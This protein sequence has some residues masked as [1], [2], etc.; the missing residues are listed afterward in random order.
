MDHSEALQQMAAERY[1]LDEMTPDA[2]EAFEEHLFDCPECALDLRAGAAFV[3]EAKAQLPGLTAA[4]PVPPSS[5]AAKSARKWNHWHLWWRPAFAIPAFA[6]LLI[7]LGYQNL[8]TLPEL[9]TEANQPRLLP[10]VPLHGATRGGAG[11]TI[12]ADRKHGVALPIDVDQ[13]PGS[14]AYT[15]YSFDLFDPEGKLAW[16]GAIAAR[17]ASE[18]GGQRILV[19]IPGA[20]LRNGAYA[21]AVFGV[22]PHGERTPMQRYA[23]DLHFT[24]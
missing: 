6:A 4:L 9:R 10:L 22:G 19:A 8:V 23:F 5:G 20:I 2:R 17:A 3:D 24:D 7:V 15:S 21:V 13:Q 1:L 12:T 18:S 14:V 11:A 16:T